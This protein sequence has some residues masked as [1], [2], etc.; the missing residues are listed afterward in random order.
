MNLLLKRTFLFLIPLLLQF[1]SCGIYS[2]TGASTEGMKTVSVQF[3]ENSAPLV[4]P[5]LSQQFTEALKERIRNQSSLSITRD[6]GDGNFEGRITDYNIRPVAVT[7]NE[8]AEATRI[9]ITVQVKYVNAI[10]NENSFEQ[11]FTRFKEL[12]GSNVQA[13]EQSAIREINQLLTEDIFNKAFA[14][15]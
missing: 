4:V 11:S 7:G 2:F 8:I 3:F 12:P 10:D 14:N 9:S 6:N 5:G 1:Q 13:Q 15:W